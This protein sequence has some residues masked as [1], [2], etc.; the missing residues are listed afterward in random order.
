MAHR[1]GPDADYTDHA[2]QAWT[3]L[4]PDA[5]LST[6]DITMR[7]RRL[8]NEL[9]H[10][11]AAVIDGTPLTAYGDYQVLAVLRRS[12]QPMQPS[13][14]A[15][16]LQVTRSGT[17]GRLNRLAELNLI[18]RRPDP[19]DARQALISITS[20]GTRLADRLLTAGQQTQA[21][22]L[23]VLTEGEQETLVNLLRKILI[24]LQDTLD[25]PHS[26]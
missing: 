10:R 6:L 7:L 8:V 15:D 9:D 22:A 5:D 12:P 25:T 14:L 1:S 16:V 19:T 11:L 4:L 13:E 24:A 23:A 2:T 21:Q 26:T 17:T 18:K 3:D 20:K